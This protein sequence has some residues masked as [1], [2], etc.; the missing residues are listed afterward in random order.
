M[1][2]YH[3]V[4]LNPQLMAWEVWVAVPFSAC[5]SEGLSGTICTFKGHENCSF[6]IFIKLLLIMP[7]SWS[8]KCSVFFSTRLFLAFSHTQ[9]TVFWKRFF[10]CFLSIWVWVKCCLVPLN[11]FIF[12]FN[13]VEIS[14]VLFQWKGI[15]RF[16]WGSLG[17]LYIPLVTS[18]LFWFKLF[19][20][21][22][23]FY[24]LG[25]EHVILQKSCLLFLSSHPKYKIS[26]DL[27]LEVAPIRIESW[28][29]SELIAVYEASVL[30]AGGTGTFPS[31]GY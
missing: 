22:T 25:S 3:V 29:C 24:H 6:L 17:F 27:W 10:T 30:V 31:H 16:A 12:I 18:I 23:K 13:L 15:V 14:K 28:M 7:V 20:A 5:V 19:M 1:A 8:A 21:L 11:P 9:N 2:P 26:R 4:C